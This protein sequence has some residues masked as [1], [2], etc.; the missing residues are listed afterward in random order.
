MP[1][2]A[3]RP[4]RRDAVRAAASG[5]GVSI[6]CSVGAWL[7]LLAFSLGAP[8]LPFIPG[9]LLLGATAPLVAFVAFFAE[10]TPLSG[11]ACVCSMTAPVAFAIWW[12]GLPPGAFS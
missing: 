5:A 10:R 3:N 6:L 11:I 7:S 12:S 4:S 9:F 2:D 1:A 8:W